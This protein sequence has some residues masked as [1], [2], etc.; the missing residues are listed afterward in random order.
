MSCRLAAKSCRDV[1]A[2]QQRAFGCAQLLRTQAMGGSVKLRN[3]PACRNDQD[4]CVYQSLVR[5]LLVLCIHGAVM[6]A[7]VC[8]TLSAMKHGCIT[9]C[10]HGP[11]VL[12]GPSRWCMPCC[13]SQPRRLTEPG[14]WQSVQ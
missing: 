10:F 7:G 8:R 9:R 13:A 1:P 12:S 6:H 2:S 3:L 4:L 14:W 11:A 5:L